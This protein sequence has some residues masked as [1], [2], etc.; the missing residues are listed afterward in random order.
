MIRG[1][2]SASVVTAWVSVYCDLIWNT[3]RIAAKKIV[4]AND[5]IRDV[6]DFYRV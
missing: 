2:A 4:V 3:L 6:L 1:T 5:L